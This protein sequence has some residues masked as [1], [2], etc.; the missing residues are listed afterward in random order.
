MNKSF[1]PEALV[2]Y[3]ND[4]AY[5]TSSGKI[6]EDVRIHF[7]QDKPTGVMVWIVVASD[8]LK[9]PLV[10]IEKGKC[11]RQ[12]YCSGCHPHFKVTMSSFKMELRYK[13]SQKWYKRHFSRFLLI[14]QLGLTLIIWTLRYNPYW[15][16][17]CHVSYT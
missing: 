2:N 11:W 7:K 9:L 16:A 8:G 5:T 12:M 6:L 17:M 14:S 13:F 3:E 1:T 4:R 15:K 10:I